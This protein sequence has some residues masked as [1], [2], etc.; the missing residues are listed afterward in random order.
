MLD[1][2]L[3]L[4]ISSRKLIFLTVFSDYYRIDWLRENN[5]EEKTN[6]VKSK[7]VEY[8]TI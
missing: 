4:Q 7:F 5:L 3:G 1:E 2:E 8:Q 6:A